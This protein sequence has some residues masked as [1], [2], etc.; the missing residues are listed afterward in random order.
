MVAFYEGNLKKPFIFFAVLN[1]ADGTG[2]QTDGQSDGWV[3][4]ETKESK[5]QSHGNGKSPSVM[6]T[7]R[8]G[9][10][11]QKNTGSRVKWAELPTVERMRI[12][13]EK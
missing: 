5:R 6:R 4:V 11:I 9:L 13:E 3:T 2:R 12:V 1:L 10:R 8:T 7:G